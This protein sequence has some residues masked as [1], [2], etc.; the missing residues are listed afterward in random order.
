MAR[1]RT[2]IT[3]AGLRTVQAFWPGIAITAGMTGGPAVTRNRDVQLFLAGDEVLQILARLA[4]EP[5]WASA[6]KAAAR[7]A[8]QHR[9]PSP[10]EEGTT[11]MT[12]KDNRNTDTTVLD[13]SRDTC[14]SCGAKIPAGDYLCRKCE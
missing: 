1:K 13:N 14:A 9:H 6:F 11:I 10:Q 8:A 7:E 5:R 3:A 4:M 2:A 12:K